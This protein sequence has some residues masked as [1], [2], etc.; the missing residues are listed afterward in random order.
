MSTCGQISFE[1][2]KKEARWGT[3]G[4]DGAEHCCGRCPE[5]KFRW[6]KLVD[7][8]T[9]HLQMILKNQRHVIHHPIRLVIEDILRDRGVVPAKFSYEAERE[10]LDKLREAERKFPFGGTNE[11]RKE[12]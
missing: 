8:D 3:Y 1:V 7:C 10:F 4:K 6:K 11:T 12:G 2:Y 5:H 9:D